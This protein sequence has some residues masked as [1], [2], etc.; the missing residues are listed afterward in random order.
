[1]FLH[2]EYES[3]NNK[4][5]EM[6]KIPKLFILL[7]LLANMSLVQAQQLDPEVIELINKGLQKNQKIKEQNVSIQQTKIDQNIAKSTF[8]PKLTFNGSFVR[9]NDDIRF[10]DNTLKLL[11]ATQKLL[12]K[13][14]VGVPFNV[15]L[16]A[17]VPLAEN[18][19]LQ[20]QN[21]LK[22]SLDLDWV[23]FSGLK[24]TNALKATQHKEASLGFVKEAIK[25]KVAL[26]IIEIYDQLGLLNASEK[27]LKTS[28]KYLKEQ[29]MY[30]N[31][32]IQTGLTTPI[33][34]KKIE[35]AKQQL[36]SKKLEFQNNKELLIEMLHQLTGTNKEQLQLLNPSPS[37]ILVELDSESKK[38]NEIKALEEAEKA[39]VF[40]SKMSKSTYIPQV[41]LKGHYEFLERD[42]S[43]LDP[44]W[45]VGIGVKWNIF[46]G[47]KSFLES[48]K[49]VLEGEKY[50][51]QIDNTKDMLNIN[52]IQSQMKYKASMQNIQSIQK[53]VELAQETYDLVKK[54]SENGL[55]VVTDVLD[56]LNDLEKANFKLQE[57]YFNQRRA[58]INLLYAKGDLNY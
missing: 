20:N 21:I 19:N 23:L 27:V 13:E 42:L 8:L 28:E 4:H 16:P 53:E 25:D 7:T 45:Y 38:R 48:K 49:A 17:N 29:E 22:S 24:V 1:M 56:A 36:K 43:L 58:V 30:V 12:I 5:K 6:D 32:A 15:P 14:A 44:K 52:I 34:R 51:T 41:A 31:K 33:S 50:R 57:S 18:P 26:K 11:T 39:T 10:D 3:F 46:D 54:Q 40:K 2:E 55:S 37:L 47:G 9:L 35:I